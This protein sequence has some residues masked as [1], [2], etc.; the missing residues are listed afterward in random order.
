MRGAV[1]RRRAALT[2]FMGSSANMFAASLQAI[3]LTPLVLHRVG[4]PLYGA[5]M[6][7]GEILVWM[8]AFDFGIPNLLVQRVGAAHAREDFVAC[9]EDF[10]A[11]FLALGVLATALAVLLYA[12]SPFVPGWLHIGGAEAATLRTC[13]VVASVS[14]CTMLLDY[15][16]HGLA[17]GL[18]DTRLIY[19]FAVLGTVVG[20][21]VTAFLLHQGYGLLSVAIGLVVRVGVAFLGSVVW[22]FGIDARIRRACH[23]RRERLTELL[24]LSV[25]MFLSGITV[26]VM[27][28]SGVTLVAVLLRPELAAVYGITKRAADLVRSLADMVGLASYGG[29]AHLRA[30]GDAH[31]AQEVYGEIHATYVAFSVAL[32]SATVAVNPSLIATWTGAASYGG[33]A[34]NALV[35]LAALAGGWSYL[36]VNLLRA[37]GKTSEGSWAVVLDG[38]VRVPLMAILAITVGL[39]GLASATIFT[40]A[41]AGLWCHRLCRR[42]IGPTPV[43]DATTWAV[44]IILFAVAVASAASLRVVG[45]PAVL[46]FGATWSAVA[47][48][49]L[50]VSDPLLK[51]RI[52][53]LKAR[54]A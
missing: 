9:G 19:R 17:R 18:Q 44:R 39:E 38:L 50:A 3:L 16:L 1:G 10:A 20:F 7:S 11:G 12:I 21:A 31:R 43:P 27:N 52:P 53:R 54:I 32:L 30:S 13:F 48:L 15:G 40:A 5:W 42:E 4:A 6:A 23:V 24:T 45:W 51:G 35:A 14:T 49:L 22:F 25:P 28:N 2:T 8:L 47:L 34:L 37:I 26:A 36:T 46:L 33:L 29:F 41:V